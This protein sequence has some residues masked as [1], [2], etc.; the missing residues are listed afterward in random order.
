MVLLDEID[1]RER[2]NLDAIGGGVRGAKASSAEPALR[3]GALIA[4]VGLAGIAA[5]CLAAAQDRAPLVSPDRIEDVASIRPDPYP[6]FDAFA[7]RAFIA[8]NW[9]SL[10]DPAHRGEP[11]RAKTLGDP[12][13]RVWETF[14]ARYELFQVG[15]DGRPIPPKPWA[16]YEARN[17]CG[18]EVGNREKTLATFTPFM[19]FNQS[20]FL[21]GV[22]ANPLVA[23]NGAY[24]RYEVRLNA[25]EYAALALSG[26]SEGEN[27]PD[28]AHPA[29]LPAGSI[30]VKAAWRP[31]TAMDTAAVRARYYV[32][33]N[34]NIVD[35][36]KTLAA[37]HTV[38]SKSDVALVGL[39][40]VIRTK[41]RPQGLWST[42]EHV[43]NVPPAGA[44]EAREPD[45][46]DADAPYS[47][48]DPSKPK[49]GLFPTF[50]TPDTLPISMDH[51]PKIDPT[52]MQVVRRHPIHG[53]TMATNRAYWALPGIKGTVWAHYMLVASQWPT[54]PNPPGPQ[55]DG[56]YFPG[57]P[58]EA[59]APRENYQ[60]ADAPH[61]N[62]VNTTIETYFQDPP[63]SCMACHQSVSNALGRDFV[64]M[65]GSFR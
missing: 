59:D 27:L 26:W 62:L 60:S 6:D 17:P 30:A 43:D 34:A 40:I 50:G 49:L 4:L 25:P 37:G 45:A 18:A 8:L 23:Q 48:F 21:P 3:A 24:T 38:C 41:D 36:A 28:P 29:R 2:A 12:G 47:Y 5:I 52:P 53:P 51:P 44:G 57:Q 33:E 63:S 35:V 13:P 14:K 46:K 22:A 19:D 61:E 20:A 39:H 55:N 42:F 56:G 1:L 31:L 11:D 54:I 16:T 64:G 9:P 32:V 65:L 58:L 15:P 10:T 7:W